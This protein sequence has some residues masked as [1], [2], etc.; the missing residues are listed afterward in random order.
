MDVPNLTIKAEYPFESSA[1]VGHASGTIPVLVGF[2]LGMVLPAAFIAMTK[3]VSTAEVRCGQKVLISFYSPRVVL[4]FY[5]IAA[6]VMLLSLAVYCFY[7]R[8]L[9]KDNLE[10]YRLE[11]DAWK[12]LVGEGSESFRSQFK[13]A[14]AKESR[15]DFQ[16]VVNCNGHEKT[17]NLSYGVIEGLNDP[18]TPSTSA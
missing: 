15:K 10:R 16:V 18:S 11:L 2:A 13:T 1:G 14:K 9:A 3:F 6:I 17:C 4:Y 7:K 8:A 12:H 5:L